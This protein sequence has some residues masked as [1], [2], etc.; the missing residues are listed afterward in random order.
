M[1][2]IKVLVVE[3][4]PLIS[5][6]ISNLLETDSELEVIG[7]AQDGMEAIKLTLAKR[8]DVITMDIFMPEMD[9]I[10]ATKQIMAKCPTPILILSSTAKN[11]ESKKTF[12]ALSYGALEVCDKAAFEGKEI[13]EKATRNLIEKVKIL[14]HAHVITHPLGN[15]ERLHLDISKDFYAIEG[16]QTRMVGIVSSTGGPEALRTVLSFL[17]QNI[18]VPILIV[19]HM[20]AGFIEG[21]VEWLRETTGHVVRMGQ[22]GDKIFPGNIYVAPSGLHMCV[23]QNGKISLKDDPPDHGEKPSGN[24]LLRSLAQFSAEKAL[25]VILTGMGEDGV[26]GLKAIYDKG[27]QTIA[28]DEKTSSV[29]GMPKAAKEKGIVDH[30]L[31][32]SDI[33]PHILKWMKMKK[34]A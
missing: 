22:N 9:G 7:K 6:I 29:W 26:L 10:E 24:Y 1:R 4:S 31:A 28:Q 30:V 19:Q 11:L 20:S 2:K 25:G 15:I 16:L 34:A 14:S 5:E 32:L 8:P 23:T 13:D 33:A 17:P 12:T 27:G 21:F 18:D 3:D